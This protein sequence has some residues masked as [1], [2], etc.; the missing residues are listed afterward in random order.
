MDF[1]SVRRVYLHFPRKCAWLGNDGTID[2]IGYIT[3]WGMTTTSRRQKSFQGIT[4][5]GIGSKL[6]CPGIINYCTDGQFWYWQA[7]KVRTVIVAGLAN[8]AWKI[9]IEAIACA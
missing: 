7:R 1:G 5:H 4:G 2:A 3:P 6:S 9:E 8:P